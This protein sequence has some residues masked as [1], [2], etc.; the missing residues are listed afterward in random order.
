[1]YPL[2]IPV[3]VPKVL[4]DAVVATC[5][6]LRICRPRADC[7]RKTTRVA[8]IPFARF[9]FPLNFIT[10]PLIANLF[11]LAILAIGREE[12]AAGT[13]G[14]DNISPIDI[15]AFFITLAYIA[16][17]LDASGLIRYLA[18]KVL[19][20][21]GKSGRRLFFYLY[22]FWFSLTA[23][24]G[25]DPIILS[26]TPFLAYMTRVAKNIDSPRAWIYTQF[27]MANVASAIL[28]SSNPTNLVLAGAFSIRFID[29]TANIVVPV[30]IT[31]V[32]LFP[33]MLYVVF[34]SEK[35][36]P[37]TI[38]MHELP[39]EA[40]QRKPVNPNIPTAAAAAAPLTTSNGNVSD[41]S[42]GAAAADTG[43]LIS[44]EEIMNPYM[45]KWSACFIACVMAVTI[46]TVLAINAGFA[47][48]GLPVPHA[49]YCTLP[50]AFL[51][52]CWDIGA[53][54][55]RRHES[56]EIARR[57]RRGH[58]AVMGGD[59][60]SSLES[61]GGRPDDAEANRLPPTSSAPTTTAATDE[62]KKQLERDATAMDARQ[63]TLSTAKSLNEEEKKEL[64]RLAARTNSS[65]T[66][67]PAPAPAAAA[68]AIAIVAQGPEPTTLSTLAARAWQWARET[69][70]NASHVLA[71]LPWALIPFAFSMFVLVQAL[72][73]KGW[74]P[75]F[76]YGWDH[77]VQATGTVGAIGGMGFLAVMLC[78]VRFYPPP[79]S[80][81]VISFSNTSPNSSPA[82]TSA[83]PS[84]SRASSRPGRRSTAR[85]ACP[86]ATAPFGPPSTAWP[87]AS[88]TA[89]SRWPFPAPSPASCGATSSPRS[90]STSAA[91]SLPASTCP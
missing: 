6:A 41:S 85:A 9:V 25:N 22:M 45:D 26:G 48:S 81:F 60:S 35:L 2:Y 62:E 37:S 47:S 83:P 7:T 39:E 18:Y 40:R 74:V 19:Q 49:F 36:V 68:A 32:L 31:A 15:M 42:G 24:I 14:A 23:F 43:K 77:W 89:P 27:T 65:T 86:S 67:I 56:R 88:T 3:Y 61:V 46:L 53:G 28:V 58:N 12:V 69:F 75:V 84:S 72:V 11:L 55:L 5:A 91:S 21:G 59:D 16:V 57:G 71:L 30:I 78:N 50:G 63:R 76:A 66:S 8:G 70:P 13:I 73:T 33:F 82:P 17:S 29:Y 38:E 64:D 4:R 20:W 10:G 90:T 54:W 79:L 34:R 87:W 1:M 80:L 51:A 52:F 44:L